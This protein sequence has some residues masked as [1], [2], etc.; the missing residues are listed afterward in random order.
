MQCTRLN[1]LIQNSQ[2]AIDDCMLAKF[3]IKLFLV[4]P[5]DLGRKIRTNY[6][7]KISPNFATDNKTCGW[8]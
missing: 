4:T 6:K 2:H 1:C 7:N 5:N 8:I 3:K